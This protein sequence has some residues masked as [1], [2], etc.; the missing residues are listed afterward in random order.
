MKQEE[1][2]ELTKSKI[3]SAAM[4]E[5]GMNGYAAGSINNICKAG[6]NKGLIYH[7]YKDKEELYLE[8]VKK[9]CEDLICYIA[10]QKAETGFVAYMSAR[11]RF[12]REHEAQGYLFLETRTNPPKQ[13]AGQIEKIYAELD[14]LNRRVFEKELADYELRSGISKEE[15][16]QYFFEMQKLYN[17]NFAN[18]QSEGMPLYEQLTLHEAYIE[19]IF[20]LMLYG[21]AIGGNKK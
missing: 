4:Q 15:A 17:L 18:R 2:T 11:M 6:I 14:E 12:F 9:T 10:E 7:N 8:C 3:L 5:F 20:D 1:K 13:L 21:I 19:K 16:I